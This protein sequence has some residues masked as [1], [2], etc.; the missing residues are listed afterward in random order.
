V[1]EGVGSQEDWSTVV[2][3]DPVCETNV[4]ISAVARAIL[5]KDGI[6]P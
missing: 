4:E 3:A 6:R 5:W 1:T 2:V